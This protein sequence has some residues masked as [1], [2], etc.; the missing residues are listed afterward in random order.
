MRVWD[1]EHGRHL[2]S[3]PAQCLA[4]LPPTNIATDAITT[5]CWTG[6]VAINGVASCWSRR[7]E[8]RVDFLVGRMTTLVLT[9]V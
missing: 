8:L 6:V 4:I 7:P 9:K 1:L 2:K 3:P 5:H